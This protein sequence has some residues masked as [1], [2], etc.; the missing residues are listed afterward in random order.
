MIRD[1]EEK[2]ISKV[3]KIINDNWKSVYAGYVNDELLSDEGC[4]K[5][6]ERLRR[7][8]L[9]N[10]LFNYVYEDNGQVVGI[11][12]IG[13]TADKD[14]KGAFELWRIYL[15]KSSQS[16]GI[17]SELIEFT[18]KQAQAKGYKEIVIWAFKDNKHAISF[19]KKHGY[20]IDKEEYLGKP[21]DAY[22]VR[23]TKNVGWFYNEI[24]SKL[25]QKSS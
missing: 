25:H 2:D 3:C 14:K 13:D 8:L 4:M 15:L 22:G 21:Y 19:Y 9:S 7:D 24:Q 23:L 5:R 6:S 12:S 20:I 1:I 10:R 18:E 11:L 17:G 16:R